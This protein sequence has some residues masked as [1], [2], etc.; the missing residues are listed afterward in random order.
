MALRRAPGAALGAFVE[1]VWV[2]AAAP[3]AGTPSLRQRMLPSGHA[4]LVL[5]LADAPLHIHGAQ[6]VVQSLRHALLGGARS[7]PY[8]REQG[9]AVPTVGAVLRPGALLLLF[10]GLGAHELAESHTALDDLWG[11]A[12][13]RLREQLAAE[14]D[15]ATRL[16]RFEAFLARRL[17]V[18]QGADPRLAR[19]M[20][21]ALTAPD[22]RAAARAS[23]L[24]QRA[25]IAAFRHGVGLGPKRYLRV[26][27]FQRV[28]R[29]LLAGGRLA[30]L[31]SGAG[32]SDQAHFNREF[33]AFVGLAPGAYRRRA[34]AEPNHLPEPVNF[35]QD[36]GSDRGETAR[37]VHA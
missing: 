6:G 27:R 5:R 31:A 21:A 33:F 36:G 25:F 2:D 12:V 14:S 22:L 24:S 10:G 3:C 17:P 13:A 29:P 4:H 7:S 35:V 28:L 32:Y 37:P 9:A 34:P 26:R 1:Q 11:A 15:D 8:L 18:E 23:G 20:Q 19:L 30:D 16:R